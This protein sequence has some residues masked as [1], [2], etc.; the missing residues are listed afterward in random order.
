[1]IHVPMELLITLCLGNWDNQELKHA[2]R[3]S[4]ITR[5]ESKLYFD[6]INFF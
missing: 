5:G 6:N 3:I 2:L 4:S 1:M